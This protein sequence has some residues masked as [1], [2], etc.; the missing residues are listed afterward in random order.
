[1]LAVVAERDPASRELIA[2]ASGA[3]GI[4]EGIAKLS[5]DECCSMRKNLRENSDLV[6]GSAKCDDATL[7]WLNISV[8]MNKRRGVPPRLL[9]THLHPAHVMSSSCL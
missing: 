2:A 9:Q 3:A 1:M 6:V 5:N 8:R 4:L 7:R